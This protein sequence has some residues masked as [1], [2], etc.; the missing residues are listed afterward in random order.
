MRIERL[1]KALII[2][3]KKNI[4]TWYS[5][6]ILQNRKV[7]ISIL[8]TF[9]IVLFKRRSIGQGHFLHFGKHREVSKSYNLIRYSFLG[10]LFGYMRVDVERL[11]LRF[12]YSA[13]GMENVFQE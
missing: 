3:N 4:L 12:V 2:G 7:N 11:G 13:E 6:Q 5:F 1:L 9:I 10:F 8:E